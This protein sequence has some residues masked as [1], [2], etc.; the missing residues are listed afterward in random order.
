LDAQRDWGYALDYVR[1]MW[2]MLQWETPGD[3]VIGTGETHSVREFCEIAFEHVSL[4]YRDL[5]VQDPKFYRPAK[6]D[7]LISD[8]TKARELVELM[9][10]ADLEQ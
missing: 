6:V 2:M 1:A 8:S 3:F 5:V 4:N 9:V 10:N 7:L